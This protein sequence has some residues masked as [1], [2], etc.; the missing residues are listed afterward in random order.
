MNEK[1]TV[2]VLNWNGGQNTIDCLESL[3]KI[4]DDNLKV[5]VVDNCSKIDPID[6]IKVQFPEFD[7]LELDKNYGYSGGNNRGFDYLKN[8]T[9]FV[10]FLNN[11]VVVDSEFIKYFRNALKNF[12]VQNIFGPKILFDNPSDKIWY[13]GGIVNLKEGLIFHKNI[14]LKE[15]IVFT[16]A[17]KTDYITGCC[18]MISRKLFKKLNG[19]NEQFNMYAEDVDLCL[20]AKKHNINCIYVP[21]SKIWHKISASTG[22]RYSI[23][24]Y[25]KKL[26]SIQKLVKIHEPNL[27]SIF[28]AI[29]TI[30][31]TLFHSKI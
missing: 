27:N 28:I 11:D 14:G 24:K 31:S 5:L 12:G 29:K 20:R 15:N 9:D 13:G 23:K 26:K 2:I 4:A 7:Y 22:G 10:C 6:K 3:E 8:D 18:L 17:G 19:F 21:K 25:I 30:F 16:K 1:I